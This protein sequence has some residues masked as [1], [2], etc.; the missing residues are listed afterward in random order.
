MDYWDILTTKNTII[1]KTWNWFANLKVKLK[2]YGIK[3]S[4]NKTNK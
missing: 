2:N 4:I 3:Y 1:Y